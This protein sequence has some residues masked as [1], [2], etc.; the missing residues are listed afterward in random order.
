MIA[1]WLPPIVPL[2]VPDVPTNIS[3]LNWQK[4]VPF[5][6]FDKF[7]EVLGAKQSATLNEIMKLLTGGTGIF[8]LPYLDIERTIESA[9]LQSNVTI[10]LTAI[11]IDGLDS[12]QEFQLANATSPFVIDSIL[13]IQKT[14]LTLSFQLSFDQGPYGGPYTSEFSINTLFQ[15][16]SFNSS[17]LLAILSDVL[18]QSTLGQL[19]EQPT[20]LIRTLYMVDFLQVILTTTLAKVEFI[21]DQGSLTNKLENAFNGI[22]GLFTN[23][24]S[25]PFT[26][27]VRGLVG[28]QLTSMAND[29]IATIIHSKFPCPPYTPTTNEVSG[30]SNIIVQMLLMLLRELGPSGIN[31]LMTTATDAVFGVAGEVRITDPFFSLFLNGNGVVLS[32]AIIKGVNTFN[33]FKILVPA[34]NG[35]MNNTFSLGIISNSTFEKSSNISRPVNAT[36]H[37]HL[38]MPSEAAND[39][40]DMS[41]AVSNIGLS[42]QAETNL[43]FTHLKEMKMIQLSNPYCV[44][45][46]MNISLKDLETG[47]NSLSMNVSGG[48]SQFVK[49]IAGL[50]NGM[51]QNLPDFMKLP[52]GT[53]EF[54]NSQI[55]KQISNAPEKCSGKNSTSPDNSFPTLW[56]GVISGS[57]A[58]VGILFISVYCHRTKKTQVVQS[59]FLESPQ[60]ESLL[61]G[62]PVQGKVQS[63]RSLYLELKG[64]YE[65][66]SS[67]ITLLTY[68]V[69]VFLLFT[70]GVKIYSLIGLVSNVSATVLQ[71]DMDIQLLRLSLIDFTFSN[72]VEYFW[73][74]DA[75]LIAFLIVGG[76]CVLPLTKIMTLLFLWFV[77]HSHKLRTA[78]L[79]FYDHFGRL[80]LIDSFFLAIM[81]ILFHVDMEQP[82]NVLAKLR[83]TCGPAI[84]AGVSSTIASSLMSHLFLSFHVSMH[85]SPPFEQ[86]YCSILSKSSVFGLVVLLAYSGIG[87]MTFFNDIS[88]FYVGGV[89]GQA[90]GGDLETIVQY[91]TLQVKYL[92]DVEDKTIGYYI[93]VMMGCLIYVGPLLSAILMLLSIVSWNLVWKRRF[94]AFLWTSLCW[95]GMDILFW[96]LFAGVLEM[97]VIAEWTINNKFGAECQAISTI[98]G[99]KCVQIDTSFR[100][101][102][103]WILGSSLTVFMAAFYVLSTWRSI[104]TISTPGYDEIPERR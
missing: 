45:S 100:S 65:K 22:A 23:D 30:P 71:K 83:A 11:T 84:L 92:E 33:Q 97:D 55:Q 28:R 74:S 13:S 17:V 10:A 4:S 96:S 79:T 26:D 44:A 104:H 54:L 89:A 81:T 75:Y 9:A 77:P 16:T 69:P 93:T 101:G 52:A 58:F 20:C 1:P 31:E 34:E 73:K 68:G 3:I 51:S 64:K 18:E 43:N 91:T 29:L 94:L 50:I 62:D 36:M 7:C 8:S 72:M 25:T 61:S 67:T 42:F 32:D 59:W 85:L 24:F 76:S 47:L 95:T 80:A 86:K 5:K 14:N 82:G 41:M 37:T 19:L 102:T 2:P 15:N 66:G 6:L 38:I 78:A 99:E 70:L 39:S 49:A 57:G 27:A 87:V 12:F 56:I 60:N 40:F 35:T 48:E 63:Q 88:R 53:T 46:T 21:P 103:W 98:M 90:A